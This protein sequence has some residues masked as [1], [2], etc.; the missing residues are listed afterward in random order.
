M[1]LP[2]LGE[3]IWICSRPSIIGCGGSV[4]SLK[5]AGKLKSKKK[6]WSNETFYKYLSL[7]ELVNL[8]IFMPQE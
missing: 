1:P 3:G 2:L 6:Y 8:G 7:C 4:S 5:F